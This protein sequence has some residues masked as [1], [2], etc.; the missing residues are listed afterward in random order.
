MA[1]D[2]LCVRVC[3][4]ALRGTGVELAA[5]L[6]LELLLELPPLLAA[7]ADVPRELEPELLGLRDVVDP[8]TEDNTLVL[9]VLIEEVESAEVELTPEV[10]EV[11]L[12]R[13]ST[14][15][16]ALRDEPLL[17]VS[18]VSSEL[19]GEAAAAEPAPEEDPAVFDA[20]AVGDCDDWI[21]RSCRLPGLR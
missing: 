3:M 18:G 7:L 10:E 14:V 4:K 8:P 17:L 15:G 16:T 9:P 12:A 11:L 6:L 5:V 13:F 1:R 20:A 2:S 21:Y 19:P